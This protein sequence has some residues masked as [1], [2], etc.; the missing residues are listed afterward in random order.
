V[1]EVCLALGH[2]LG[3]EAEEVATLDIAAQLAQ[4]GKVS[5]PREI[6]AKTDR[7]TPEE[8]EIMKTHVNNAVAILSG[9][10]F[11]MPVVDTLAQS[12]ERMDGSGYPKGLKNDEISVL[13]RLLGVADV[14]CARIEPRSYRDPITP[15]EALKVFLD[16]ADKYDPKVVAALKDY[17]GTVAGEKFVAQV[18]GG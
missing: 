12:Y 5:I 11:G 4:I 10:D 2:I 9:V 1:H 3:L 18:Q 6:V 14:F 8:I 17:L 16:N 15:A 7:L 13:A